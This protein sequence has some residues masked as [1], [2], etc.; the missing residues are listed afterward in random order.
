MSGDAVDGEYA[1][2]ERG[3]DLGRG[4][5]GGLVFSLVGEVFEFIEQAGDFALGVL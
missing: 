2:S 1:W 4:L 5:F 3:A